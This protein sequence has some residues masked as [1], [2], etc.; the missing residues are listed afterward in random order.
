M[1]RAKTG[2]KRT[3]KTTRAGVGQRTRRPASPQKTTRKRAPAGVR[4][5][6]KTP[7]RNVRDEIKGPSVPLRDLIRGG[8]PRSPKAPAVF[9]LGES[10]PSVRRRMKT[11]YGLRLGS[12]LVQSP[13]GPREWLGVSKPNIR[14]R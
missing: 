3:S 5:T 13:P 14:K 7:R 11:A 4:R 10:A 2:T 9:D 8:M 1:A 6:R 12:T